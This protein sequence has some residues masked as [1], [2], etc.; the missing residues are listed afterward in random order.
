MEKGKKPIYDKWWFWIIFG[1]VV[2][3]LTVL[4]YIGNS[5]LQKSWMAISSTDNPTNN[6]IAQ[7]LIQDLM[8]EVNETNN[9]SLENDETTETKTSSEEKKK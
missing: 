5:Q 1:V 9:Y 7:N 6:E 2:V 3:V 4:M 8:K